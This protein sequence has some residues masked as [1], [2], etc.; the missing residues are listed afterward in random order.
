MLSRQLLREIPLHTQW[1]RFVLILSIFTV[2]SVLSFGKI[3]ALHERLKFINTT[4]LLLPLL[5]IGLLVIAQL[6]TW[7]RS[8]FASDGF[9]LSN[10]L[11]I[12]YLLLIF[13][14]VFLLNSYEIVL[15]GTSCA[16]NN[17]P[18]CLFLFDDF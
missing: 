9:K 17:G 5:F 13:I 1:K 16:A 11:P 8:N 6:A 3:A 12:E 15:V 2:E 4:F 10:L 18:V 7:R 14:L